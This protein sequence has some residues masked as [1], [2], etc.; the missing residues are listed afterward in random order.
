MQNQQLKE[1]RKQLESKRNE[2][3]RSTGDRDEI[4]IQK[5]ADEFDQLQLAMNREVAIRNLDRG[6]TLLRNVEAALTR[7]DNGE[8]GTCLLCE[9]DIP[10]KR[11][12]AVPWA[13]Y[14]VGCQEML[15]RAQ[16]QGGADEEEEDIQV[17]VRR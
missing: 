8:F 9:E 13:A 16:A 14:C 3:I 17:A 1:Y 4:L 5:A 7:M 6:A 15:D 12:K 2:L 11:L 10:E